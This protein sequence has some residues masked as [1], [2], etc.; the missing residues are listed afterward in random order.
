MLLDAIVAVII[1]LSMAFGFRAGFVWSF[2]HLAGWLLSIVIAFAFA[3]KLGAFLKGNTGFYSSMH[4]ALASR[5]EDAESISRAAHALPDILGDMAGSLM[6][7]A[8]V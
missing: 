4:E 1:I 6:D 8:A 3:P 7:K 2:L 5:F